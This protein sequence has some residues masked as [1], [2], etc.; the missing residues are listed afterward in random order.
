MPPWVNRGAGFSVE[1]LV[2]AYGVHILITPVMKS[3]SFLVVPDEAP[4]HSF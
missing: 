1:P 4:R 2:N 3:N